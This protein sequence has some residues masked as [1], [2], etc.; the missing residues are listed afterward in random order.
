MEG[1]SDELRFNVSHSHGLALYAVTRRRK[2]GIDIE[3]VRPI[4]GP[5]QLA[6]RFFSAGENAELC[7]LPEHVKHEAFFN[8]WTRKEAYVK[9]RGEGLSLPLNQFDVSLNP[10]EPARL[11]RVERDPQE[12]AR[13]SLQGLTPAPGYVA[14]LAVEGHGWRLACWEWREV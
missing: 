5:E 12:A 11:L 8:C 3:R 4:S 1:V 9:A 10:G 14:A 2:I 6:A 13:W 7:A